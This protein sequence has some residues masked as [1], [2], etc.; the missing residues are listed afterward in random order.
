ME[1]KLGRMSNL[2]VPESEKNER[3]QLDDFTARSRTRAAISQDGPEV[4]AKIA[5]RLQSQ[6]AAVAKVELKY[7]PGYLADLLVTPSDERAATIGVVALANSFM[8]SRD[9]GGIRSF[10]NDATGRAKLDM[11]VEAAIRG[12]LRKRGLHLWNRYYRPYC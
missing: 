5:D 1:P 3:R 4:L 7:E 12:R 8:I 10:D 9:H 2:G 11:F 6:L